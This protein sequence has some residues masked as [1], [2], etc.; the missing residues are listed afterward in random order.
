MTKLVFSSICQKLWKKNA[1]KIKQK[2]SYIEEVK[3]EIYRKDQLIE[4]LKEKFCKFEEVVLKMTR[5]WIYFILKKG[6]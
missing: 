1:K 3:E 4:D 2:N 6:S 5:T